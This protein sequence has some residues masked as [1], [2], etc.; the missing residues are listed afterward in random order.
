MDAEPR[1]RQHQPRR[2]RLSAKA[3]HG[4]AHGV[5]RLRDG[6]GGILRLPQRDEATLCRRPRLQLQVG[7][8]LHARHARLSG[9]RPL[10]PQISSRQAD[11][12][13]DVRLLRELHP[14][15]FARRGRA[16]QEVDARQDV[17]HL[18]AEVCHAAR[19]L[20]L[21]VRASGQEAHVHGLGIRPVHRVELQAGARL[22]A[23]RLP[24]AQ[25]H[26]ALV[27][28]A[29]RLLPQ[30]PRALGHRRRLGRL[31][32]AERG[33]RRAQRHRLPAHGAQRPPGRV[34]LQ[35]HARAL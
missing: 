16:R 3:Q 35:L 12:L 9:A 33:R 20:R 28:R 14:R 27:Q 18:R 1:R 8:G 13:N 5:A 26:A 17:R 29:Q 24:D 25:G 30:H 34:R 4:R 19:T 7:H 22:A 31:H 2:G 21:S 32:V 10:L 23:A 11:V 6:R 15:V